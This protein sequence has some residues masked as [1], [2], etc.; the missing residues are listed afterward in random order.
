MQCQN[1][2]NIVFDEVIISK[3]IDTRYASP[4]M[5]R[6]KNSTLLFYSI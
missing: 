1:G 5:F 3:Y 2:T 6:K 4:L